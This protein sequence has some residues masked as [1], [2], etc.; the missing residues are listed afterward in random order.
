MK[1]EISR[2]GF[3]FGTAAAATGIA[4]GCRTAGTDGFDESL[5]VIVSDLHIG[6]SNPNITYTLPAFER[7]V[8]E[9]LAMDPLPRHVIC[10]GDVALSFGLDVDYRVS[11]PVLRRLVDAGIDL[12]M[13]MGNHDR[14]SA[15]LKCWPEYAKSSPVPGR[16]V[17]VIPLRDADFVLLD[18]LKGT[19]DRAQD[20]YGPVDG[21]LD[22]AQLAWLEDWMSKATR[23]FFVGTHQGVDLYLKGDS[24]AKRLWKHKLAAGWIYGHDHEWLPNYRIAKWGTTD[25]IPV[26]AVP[27]TGL[28]GDIGYVTLR[29]S[30]NGAVAELRQL[31]FYFPRPTPAAEHP[32]F[33]KERVASHRGAV[34][35]FTFPRNAVHGI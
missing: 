16:I 29:T 13:T 8:D 4:A 24:F 33:W 12:R 30:P 15:F 23:P 35:S 1:T 31:D 20:D 21:T 11:K 25:V 27:S 6:G 28:W 32:S 17:S 26:L 10:L 19:D 7:V 3:I 18:A 9:I 5:S 2:R 34:Q 22:D 14:R